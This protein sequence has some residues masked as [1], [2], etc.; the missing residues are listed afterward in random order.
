[1]Q[2][3]KCGA[4][5]EGMFCPKCGEKINEEQLKLKNEQVKNK[6]HGS[7]LAVR[8]AM[9]I[10]L[11]CFA[12]PFF[13]VS[14][15]A[16]GEKYEES[17]S[18]FQLMAGGEASEK[19]PEGGDKP[20]NA[21]IT[22]SFICAAAALGIS[23]VKSIKKFAFAPSLLSAFMLAVSKW[24]FTGYYDL[25]DYKQYGLKVSASGGYY[26]VMILLVATAAASLVVFS[27]SEN[28]KLAAGGTAL[29]FPDNQA[30]V[31]QTPPV[32]TDTPVQS[33]GEAV[34]ISA[35]SAGNEGSDPGVISDNDSE[36][37]P[38]TDLNKD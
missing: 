24:S 22:I 19:D 10:T 29:P 31:R 4:D 35:P 33:A 14:C 34:N 23:L 21:F 8:I 20:G 9:L 6:K 17:Y 38:K 15:S 28:A 3:K 5:F 25:K 12:L 30:P 32:N 36:R 37:E 2:C 26:I 27:R 18:G 7:I 13:T 1:M 11:I 16:Y